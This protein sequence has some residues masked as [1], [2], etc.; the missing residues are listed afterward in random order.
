M[1]IYIYATSFLFSSIIGDRKNTNRKMI[2]NI[3]FKNWSF[4]IGINKIICDD[5]VYCCCCFF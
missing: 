2:T 4:K 3:T 1:Y 5:M